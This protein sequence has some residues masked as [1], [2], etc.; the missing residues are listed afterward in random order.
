MP[1][2][3]PSRPGIVV[4]PT[5]W[6]TP[7]TTFVMLN[8]IP[9]PP[10][11][12]FVR[13]QFACTGSPTSL[14]LK[15]WIFLFEDSSCSFGGGLFTLPNVFLTFVL[16]FIKFLRRES[17][18]GEEL[19]KRGQPHL[20]TFF[21]I[22]DDPLDDVFMKPFLVFVL[23]LFKLDGEFLPVIEGGADLRKDQHKRSI[24][25][26]EPTYGLQLDKTRILGIWSFFALIGKYL[27]GLACPV[28]VFLFIL[29]LGQTP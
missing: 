3:R 13:P 12:P 17:S 29:Y 5:I 27:L 10:K 25:K 9:L 26:I 11:R 23:R 15:L 6:F 14:A 24:R 8:K 21:K 16:D 2:T 7:P 22:R 4:K 1:R 28:F 20:L 18:Q 19:G